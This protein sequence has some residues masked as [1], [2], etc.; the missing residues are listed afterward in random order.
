[1]DIEKTSAWNA[2]LAGVQN[3]QN[4]IVDALSRMAHEDVSAENTVAVISATN[5]FQANIKV[6]KSIDETTGYLL[7]MV[8]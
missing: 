8:V 5:D 1:M 7:D 2:A 3:A 6:M 4:R